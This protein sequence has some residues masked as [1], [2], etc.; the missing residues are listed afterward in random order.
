MGYRV[1]R[2]EPRRGR[3]AG[4]FPGIREMREAAPKLGVELVTF[5]VP[6]TEEAKAAFQSFA[7]GE[8]DVVFMPVDKTVAAAG[9][10]L[11]QLIK[12]DRILLISPS[13]VRGNSMMSYSPDL[14]DLGAQMGV[15]V[16]KVLDGADP[17]TLPVELPR[18]Q[19][20]SLFLGA[21]KEAGYEFSED[22]LALADVLV[23]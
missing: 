18:V 5:E 12:H 10:S 11:R 19:E 9:E 13:G 4:A 23:E 22:A 2:A 17:G 6:G 1:R 7:P 14:R 15:M 21:A 3:Y 20:L 16:A 8:I